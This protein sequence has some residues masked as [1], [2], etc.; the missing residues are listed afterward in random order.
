ME[1]TT[2]SCIIGFTGISCG[3][4]GKSMEEKENILTSIERVL[5][6]LTTEQLKSVY[7]FAL[8]CSR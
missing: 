2:I 1:F 4:K 8:H 5:K 7:Q 6:D 3:G